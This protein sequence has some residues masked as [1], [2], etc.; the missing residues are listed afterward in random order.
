M[1]V[2]VSS[3]KIFNPITTTQYAVI[4]VVRDDFELRRLHNLVLLLLT[5]LK[6]A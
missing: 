6:A 2:N 4:S 5:L 3:L 1:H